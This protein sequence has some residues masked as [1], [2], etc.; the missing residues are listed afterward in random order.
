MFRRKDFLASTMIF[1]QWK[2]TRIALAALLFGLFR[3]AR[4]SAKQAQELNL[5]L[6]QS[7]TELQEALVQ[8]KT[9]NAAKTTFLNNMSHDIRTPMNALMGYTMMLKPRL[10]DEQLLGPGSRAALRSNLLLS[11]INHVLDMARIESG[12][13]EVNEVYS[14]IGSDAEE[15]VAVFS[16]EAKKKNIRLLTSVQVEHVHIMCDITKIR[17]I[18]S[19]LISNAIKYTPEGGT[20]EFNVRELPCS[21]PGYACIQ[22]EI[23]DNGMGMSKEYLPTLFDAFTR[24]RNTHSSACGYHA[25]CS[26]G[27]WSWLRWRSLPAPAP[28]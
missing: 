5:K 13:M 19:N 12:K 14:K 8:A 22:T 10:K 4:Q 17:E 23:A 20:V 15:L 28:A 2:P 25:T 21:R 9:A 24:E 1:G 27:S 3:K 18:F 16:V 7:Q 6:Q 11:I 26:T